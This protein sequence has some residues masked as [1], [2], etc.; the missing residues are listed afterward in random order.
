MDSTFR[1][2]IR[3]FVI[4]IGLLAA[5]LTGVAIILFGQWRIG[6]MPLQ[7]LPPEAWVA[8][9]EALFTGTFLVTFLVCVMWLI[10]LAGILLAETFAVRAWLFHVTNGALSAFVGA[11][12][13]PQ[14]SGEASP[15]ADTFY[16]LASGLAG[17]LVYWLVAGWSAGFWKPVRTP[18]PAVQP[19]PM[20]AQPRQAPPPLPPGN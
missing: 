5:V 9:M 11:W 13:F 1:F 17:G 19:P 18:A 10:G 8:V 6:A 3:L 7:D 2:F 14:V 20:P 12:L 4:P 15:P 16:I